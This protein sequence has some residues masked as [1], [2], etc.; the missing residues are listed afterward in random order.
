MSDFGWGLALVA[1]YVALRTVGAPEPLILAWTIAAVAATIVSP[2]LGL[3]VLAAIGPFTGAVDDN[4]QITAV[5]F[6]LAALGAGLVVQFATTRPLP[7]FRPPWPFTAWPVVLAV[8]LMIGT[9]LGVAHSWLSYGPERGLQAAQLWVPGIGGAMT[10]LLAAV[11]VARRG[12]LR[13]LYVVVVSITLAALLALLDFFSMGQVNASALGWLLH[14]QVDTN[15]LGG[16]ILAPDAAATI[17]LVGV[18]VS[19]AAALLVGRVVLRLLA[20]AAGLVTLLAVLLTY[21]RSAL[22]VVGLVA[23][24]VG[25]RWR[26]WVGVAAVASIGLIAVV[27]LTVLMNGGVLRDVPAVADQARVDAWGAAVRM[28]LADPLLGQG[29]RS[30]EWLHAA[31]GSPVLDAAHNEWLR[32]FAEEGTVIGLAGIGFGLATLWVILRGRTWL[33][34]GTAA[35]MAGLIVMACFNNP[36]LYAQVNIPAFIVIGTGLG[37]AQRAVAPSGY[38]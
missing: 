38:P 2:V 12:E 35:A 23:L 11:W 33:A 30:F 26:R 34:A 5:P 29:F 10:V 20:L 13:P 7:R 36:F 21:S 6:L 1:L 8:V 3:T 25:W 4:G 15:R 18:S 27:G 37:L 17:F 28:W 9:A 22:I 14:D 19:A 32:L 16:I 31:Y 24:M